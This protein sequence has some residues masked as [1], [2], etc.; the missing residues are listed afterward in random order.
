MI[1]V[2]ALALAGLGVIGSLFVRPPR[3]VSSAT[4]RLI[5]G[6][7]LMFVLAPATRFGYFMYP[8]GLWAWLIVSQLG[9]RRVLS[10]GR[11]DEDAAGGPPPHGGVTQPSPAC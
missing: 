7:V 6:L 3:D 11:S 2:G 10:P 9:T 8:L 4:W 1:A 5:I